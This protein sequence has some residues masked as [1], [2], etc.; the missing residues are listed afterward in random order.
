MSRL[1]ER[2]AA[3]RSRNEKALVCFVTAGDPTPEATV[4][5][6]ETLAKAGADCVEIGLPFSDPLADGPS[7]QASSQRALDKGMTVRKAL[8]AIRQIRERVPDL[9]LVPMTYYNPIHHFGLAEYARAAK[10]AGADGHIVSDLTPEEA[11]EWK[12]ISASEGLDT[13]FLLAPTST[14]ERI[15]IVTALSEGFVYCV[16]RTGVTGVRDDIPAELK[17]VVESIK[18][19]TD[20]PVFVGFGISRPEHV[21]R[22][23]AFAD[24]VVVGSSLVNLIHKEKE[25]PALLEI[26]HDYVASLKAATK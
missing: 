2:F 3:L 17:D 10:E 6:V 21:A 14:L 1:S 12:R 4:A 5:I 11:G 18:A 8:D 25:N 16:S 13:I 22:I 9:P 20:K 23:T 7:I 15:E 19:R 26:V 24:G